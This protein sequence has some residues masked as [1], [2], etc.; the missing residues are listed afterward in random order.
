MGA[1]KIKGIQDGLKNLKL[2]T[3]KK[4]KKNKKNIGVTLKIYFKWER[5]HFFYQLNQ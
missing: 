5:K 2:S 1:F 3:I 4:K